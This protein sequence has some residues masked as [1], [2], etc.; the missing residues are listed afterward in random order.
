MKVPPARAETFLSRLG[1]DIH[2]ILL[3]GPD[4]GLVRERARAAVVKV[5]GGSD[6]PFLVAEMTAADIRADPARV[7]DEACALA[8]GGGR[9]AV[10]LRGAADGAARAV[11]VALDALAEASGPAPSLL[12]VE[13]G[14]LGPRSS[15]RNLFEGTDRVAAIPCYLD[16]GPGL[17]RVIE[18]QLFKRG[19]RADGDARAWLAANLGADRG[20]TMGEL[21]K[22][23]LYCAD[24]KEVTLENCRAV[25][26]DGAAHDLE[27]AVFAA[28]GGEG[29]A[30]DRAL[31]R[32]FQE[33]VNP[34]T[35]LRA[36][37]RHF[38]RLH[39]VAGEVAGGRSLDTAV[40]GLK[41]PVFFK[42]A[43]RFRAQARRWSPATLVTALDLLTE[44]ELRC[45][46]TGQPDRLI[47]QRTLMQ[48]ANAARQAGRQN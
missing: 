40:K 18:A 5:T 36:A 23:A 16:E 9:R 29:R 4:S 27:D 11:G 3:Y 37:Q 14:E 42:L 35:I 13:A 47:C 34:V 26:G 46:S 10:R 28:G 38:Q 17:E 31:T 39:L 8:F 21:E 19:L 44:A 7:T 45:K 1:D 25:V 12:I 15:L 20:V 22:L 43:Q 41:P 2:A 48:I 32:V 6:D 24:T 33:G 30:L